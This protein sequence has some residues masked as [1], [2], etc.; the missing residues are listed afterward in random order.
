MTTRIYIAATAAHL[1]ELAGTGALAP[2]LAYAVTPVLRAM[3]EAADEE[4]LEYAAF[5]EA[6]TGSLALLAGRGVPARRVVL[7][8]DVPD[9]QVHVAAE[10]G[11]A[12]VQ[13]ACQVPR[14]AVASVHVD[15]AEAEQ[16]VSQAVL[17]LQAAA[18]GDEDALDALGEVG[19]LDLLWYATQEIPDLLA[20]M[21]L[22]G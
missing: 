20:E 19:G 5:D 9:D 14:S 22:S 15:E 11:D 10:R 3:H 17:H 21:G 8:A 6:A 13:V 12:A 7:S 2:G 4:E 18:D 16:E 1:L